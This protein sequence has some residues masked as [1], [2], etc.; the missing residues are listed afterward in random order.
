MVNFSKD[1]DSASLSSFKITILSLPFGL[2]IG[3]LSLFLQPNHL[4][5][6]GVGFICS[7]FSVAFTEAY[8]WR[9]RSHSHKSEIVSKVCETSDKTGKE[10]ALLIDLVQKNG[11]IFN[12]VNAIN[13]NTH[14]V[15]YFSN[16]EDGIRY[17]ESACRIATHVKNTV[18]RYGGATCS[19]AADDI[20]YNAWLA[21]KERS[22]EIKSCLW[23]E[24]VSV[25]FDDNDNQLTLMKK[26]SV[27]GNHY[28][29]GVFIDDKVHH[30]VQMTIF[31]FRHGKEIIFGWEFPGLEHG[32][33]F[34]VRN[35]KVVD[36]F[37]KYFD[38]HFDKFGKKEKM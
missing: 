1:D 37:E 28:Y 31:H 35:E 8:Y 19:G 34:L 14:N 18:L 22:L 21:A 5:S 9:V 23:S 10:I 4:L 30:L 32:P 3:V 6:I 2:G 17:C 26:Y 11:N 12:I 29:K 27:H 36:Y 38:F 15:I 33:S 16:T 7:V 13:S 20:V 24:L 25:H